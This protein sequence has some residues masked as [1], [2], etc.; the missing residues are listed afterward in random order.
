MILSSPSI[1]YVMKESGVLSPSLSHLNL[2]LFVYMVS[3]IV[4]FCSNCMVR[5]E[6][7]YISIGVSGRVSLTTWKICMDDSSCHLRE[8]TLE[9]FCRLQDLRKDIKNWSFK[10]SLPPGSPFVMVREEQSWR[11]SLSNWPWDN[12]MFSNLYIE[13][14]IEISTVSSRIGMW[15]EIIR[16]RAR[17]EDRRYWSSHSREK[18]NMSNFIK[19]GGYQSLLHV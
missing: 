15:S 12:H 1:G 3:S 10:T 9:K 19:V 5:W 7:W 6:R 4:W 16:G 17:A 2:A 13:G 11:I 14:R 18:R 8:I